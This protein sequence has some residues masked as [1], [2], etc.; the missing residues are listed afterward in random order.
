MQLEAGP[1]TSEAIQHTTAAT[2]QEHEQWINP[3]LQRWYAERKEW[4][5][6][7]VQPRRP[8]KR[9]VLGMDAT[10]DELLTSNKPFAESVP[11]TEMVEFLVDTWIQDSMYD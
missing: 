8:P 11:L 3:G 5:T 2:P 6:P 10:Y 1:S 4:T 9:N 7:T